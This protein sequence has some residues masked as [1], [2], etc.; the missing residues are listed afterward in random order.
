M[1]RPPIATQ[2]EKAGDCAAI[3]YQTMLAVPA[4]SMLSAHDMLG[5]RHGWTTPER[6]GCHVQAGEEGFKPMTA[7]FHLE[8]IQGSMVAH[9]GN[10]FESGRHFAL[11]VLVC[12]EA[13]P[14]GLLNGAVFHWAVA[15]REGGTWS[16]PPDGWQSDPSRTSAA[17]GFPAH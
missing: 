14:E 5:I 10:A 4:A 17:G 2:K 1:V 9:V 7:G 6:A 8:G 3:A 16:P 12:S 13:F 11:V 15:S